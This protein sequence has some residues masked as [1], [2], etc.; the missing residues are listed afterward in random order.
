ME[1]AQATPWARTATAA[2]S[3]LRRESPIRPT[4]ISPT[5]AE[6]NAARRGG[7][8]QSNAIGAGF[9]A[10]CSGSPSSWSWSSGSKGAYTGG[11]QW[12]AAT[13]A[14][15]GTG[16]SGKRKPGPRPS[17]SQHSESTGL[18]APDSDGTRS[19]TKAAIPLLPCV[20]GCGRRACVGKSCC[21]TGW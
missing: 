7:T 15:G 11:R 5:P 21:R 2:A 4:S 3:L 16:A 20:S 6:P 8:Y 18:D 17:V 19:T 1:P 13:A 10:G 9:A 12:L 14:A